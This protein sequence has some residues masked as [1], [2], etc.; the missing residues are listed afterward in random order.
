MCKS[1]DEAMC[2]Y[3]ENETIETRH[4]NR[5]TNYYSNSKNVLIF[6]LFYYPANMLWN[7]C[8]NLGEI[9]L[10]SSLVLLEVEFFASIMVALFR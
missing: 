3:G 9:P 2:D 5:S 10:S 1:T 4:R 8:A 6:G 7:M